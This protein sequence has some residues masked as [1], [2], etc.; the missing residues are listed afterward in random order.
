MNHLKRSETQI[1]EGARDLCK[2]GIYGDVRQ[3]TTNLFKKHNILR[4]YVFLFYVNLAA[5][6]YLGL[7][8]I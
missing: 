5:P 1:P 3:W 7:T 6:G 8:I 2:K 4:L